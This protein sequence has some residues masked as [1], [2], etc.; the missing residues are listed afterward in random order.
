MLSVRSLS[1]PF[2]PPAPTLVQPHPFLPA[3]PPPQPGPPCSRPAPPQHMLARKISLKYCSPCAVP[4]LRNQK[5][6]HTALEMKHEYVCKACA[7]GHS[8]VCQPHFPP[9]PR[10]LGPVSPGSLS[11]GAGLW[12]GP[13]CPASFFQGSQSTLCFSCLVPGT[14]VTNVLIASL[15]VVCL[16]QHS[17]VL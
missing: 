15:F 1:P 17:Q 11:P 8:L 14:L 13:L 7:I 16:P 3:P 4:P 5:W 6:L 9:L 10:W 2:M 12:L